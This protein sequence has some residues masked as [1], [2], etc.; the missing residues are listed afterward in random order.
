MLGMWAV[1]SVTGVL[2][3]ENGQDGDACNVNFQ[4]LTRFY[5]K[6]HEQISKVV[7]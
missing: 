5:I 1:E 3:Q 7:E 2:F 6:K 4:K